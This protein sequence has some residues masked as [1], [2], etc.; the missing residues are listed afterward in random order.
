MAFNAMGIMAPDNPAIIIEITIDK[1]MMTV[2][3]KDRLQRATAK[4][5]VAETANPLKKAT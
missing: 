2:K 4:Q 5:A 3:P 1:P